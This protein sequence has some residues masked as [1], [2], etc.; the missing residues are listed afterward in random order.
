VSSERSDGKKKSDLP[1]LV[2]PARPVAERQPGDRVTLDFTGPPLALPGEDAEG[3][4]PAPRAATPA[5]EASAGDGPSTSE[6]DAWTRDRQRRGSSVHPAVSPSV[7]PPPLSA[8][9]RALPAEQGGAIDLVDRS[10]PPTHEM[11]LAKEMSDRYALGDF[12][13]ALRAAQLLLGR[14]PD[15]RGARRYADNSVERLAQI[16]GSR[17]GS[18]DR[19]PRVIVPEQE[20]R[21]LGIDYK[22]GFLLSR[23]DG[24]HTLEEIIDVSGMPRLEALRML[25][26][27]L[28]AGAIALG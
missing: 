25:A 3:V 15:H 18:L 8:D 12:T 22:A 9:P 7:N 23:V 14:E 5:G 17:L 1:G 20:V 28:E 24:H 10:R 21:W 4:G 26:E 11:D 19:V 27:L 2:A 6:H 16:Y 13:G